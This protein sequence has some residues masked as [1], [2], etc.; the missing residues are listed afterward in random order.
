MSD[1]YSSFDMITSS[2]ENG[3]LEPKGHKL[4]DRKIDLDSDGNNE[5]DV[6]RRKSNMTNTTHNDRVNIDYLVAS[7]DQKKEIINDTNTDHINCKRNPRSLSK[8]THNNKYI[9]T[10]PAKIYGKDAPIVMNPLK[11]CL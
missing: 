10:R 11:R 9:F 3:E 2:S 7:T 4:K 6:L 5:I 8:L 1:T